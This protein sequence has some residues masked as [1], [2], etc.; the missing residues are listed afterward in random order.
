MKKG[1]STS[2]AKNKKKNLR[3]MKILLVLQP[4]FITVLPN[5]F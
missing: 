2:N 4:C 1:Y 5:K 3:N